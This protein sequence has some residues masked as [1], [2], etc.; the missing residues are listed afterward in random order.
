LHFEPVESSI[1][2][3]LRSTRG[4]GCQNAGLLIGIKLSTGFPDQVFE[5]AN[6]AHI[7][8]DMTSNKPQVDYSLY[9]V[10][11]RSL[12]PEGYDFLEH[13]E[14]CLKGGVTLVQLREKH[15]DT[16]PFIEL[17]KQTK[18]VTEKYNVPL[19]I[20]DRVDVALAVDAAGVHVGQDDMPLEQVRQFIGDNKI[21]GVSVNNVHEAAEAVSAGSDYLGIGAVWFTS[22]KTLTKKPLGV[23]GV[24]SKANCQFYKSCTPR[25]S[26]LLIDP[27]LLQLFSSPLRAKTYLR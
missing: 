4:G 22:T 8:L 12:L 27:L 23:E 5:L 3:S 24:Q 7:A 14:M 13:L 2:F 19:I 26:Y 16:R 25:F 15:L 1:E 11:E 17:A 18:A 21:I 9:L 20:N 10:T 6:L